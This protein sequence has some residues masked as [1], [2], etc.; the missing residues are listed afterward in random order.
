MSRSTE[1][2]FLRPV[3]AA[4]M[5]SISRSRVY[6]LLNAGTLPGLRIE[7]RTW[8]IPRAAIEKMA[9]D[10]MDTPGDDHER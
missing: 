1:P 5:L 2:I 4:R 3:E 6:E 8:R 10:A 7:G 9:R